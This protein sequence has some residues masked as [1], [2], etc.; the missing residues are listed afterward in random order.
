MDDLESI[1]L[2]IETALQASAKYAGVT[3]SL[4]SDFG[5]LLD[6]HSEDA[7]FLTVQK[8][9]IWLGIFEQ[10]IQWLSSFHDLIGD[11]VKEGLSTQLISPYAV[12]GTSIA[13]AV[14]IRRLCLA[15]LDTPARSILR[16]FL[17]NIIL[18]ILLLFDYEALLEFEST[19][20]DDIGARKFWSKYIRKKY[21]KK[22]GKRLSKADCVFKEMLAASGHDVGETETILRHYET[23]MI[24]ISQAV[25]TSLSSALF[26]TKSISSDG[27][28]LVSGKYG[29]STLFSAMTL[30]RASKWIWVFSRI[31]HPLIIAPIHKNE[32]SLY[33]IAVDSRQGNDELVGY[34]A[35]N[36]L[37]V[38]HWSDFQE[39][40]EKHGFA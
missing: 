22:F 7:E 37:I 16:N 15:G 28:S 14:S 6:S 23:E 8:L 36:I 24:L 1:H 11:T 2:D 40:I 34:F 5:R 17:E 35:I 38:N 39:L 21:D 31:V 30:D 9:G 26:T 33:D 3:S 32:D 27:D 18:I 29:A 19:T 4:R 20:H 12:I 13:Q 25:H 10:C